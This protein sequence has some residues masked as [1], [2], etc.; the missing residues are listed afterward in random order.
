MIKVLILG[1]TG[2]VGRAVYNH[3]Q[4]LSFVSCFATSVSPIDKTLTKFIIDENYIESF[5]KIL[6]YC[7]PDYV[8]NCIGVIR[9]ENTLEGINNSILVN[10]VFPR[11]AAKLCSLLDIRFIHISTDCVFDGRKGN[12]SDWETPNELSIYGVTKYLGEV[13]EPPHLTIRTSIVGRETNT[14]KNL[15]EWFLHSKGEVYG[16]NKVYWNG[17]TTKTLAKVI[18]RIIERNLIFQPGIIHLGSEKISKYQLLLIFK[19]IFNLPINVIPLSEKISD[20]TL[21]PSKAQHTYFSDLI[22][23]LEIQIG[24]LVE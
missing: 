15:L 22:T 2:M 14:T 19:K 8:I 5:K 18:A 3:F 6:T 20:K 16:Y 1:S 11:S 10:S 9:P 23:P 24:E 13:I 17:I 7:K 12:Y 4:H 21:V